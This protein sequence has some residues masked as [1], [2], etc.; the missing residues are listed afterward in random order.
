MLRLLPDGRFHL[1]SSCGGGNVTLET[2]R[3][4]HD[5]GA[6]VGAVIILD[7]GWIHPERSDWYVP[8][9]RPPLW[10]RLVTH[11]LTGRLFTKVVNFVRT[12]Y[13]QASRRRK[14][15]RFRD[16]LDEVHRLAFD[17]YWAACG[18]HKP[19]QYPRRLTMILTQEWTKHRLDWPARL[20]RWSQIAVGG[21]DIRSLPG[22][23]EE[24][25]RPP[26]VSETCSVIASVMRESENLAGLEESSR[27]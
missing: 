10:R 19:P 12:R 14:A 13:R 7:P 5:A 11:A 26:R 2:A 8:E 15:D 18:R 3:Q 25:L 20:A 21:I 1:F 27:H 9:E 6:N 22:W 16:D 17:S 24:A 4:L 23:H